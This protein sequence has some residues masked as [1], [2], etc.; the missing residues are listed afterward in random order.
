MEDTIFESM[1]LCEV[2]RCRRFGSGQH[3]VHLSLAFQLPHG[4]SDRWNAFAS[5]AV[6]VALSIAA[7]AAFAVWEECL[8]LIIGLW[9]IVSPWLLKFQGTRAMRV[10]IAVGIIVAAL[11]AIK[12]W[13]TQMPTRR[14]ANR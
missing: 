11:A 3:P 5:G 8:D 13:T 4:A 7:L 2:V 10:D 9:L 14:A 6:I 12:L 1:D